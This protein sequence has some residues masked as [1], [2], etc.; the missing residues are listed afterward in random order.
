M[1]KVSTSTFNSLFGVVKPSGPAS[2]TIVNTIKPLLS[3]SPLFFPQGEGGKPAIKGK[4]RGKAALK[5]MVKIGTGG[6]LDPLA[7]GVL[8]LGIGSGTKQLASFLDCVKEYKTTCLLGCETDSYDSQGVRVRVAP[9][10][11]V[12]RENIEAVLDRFRGEIMQT[13]PIFSALK[14]DGRP[15]YEYA[16]E[17]IP[18]PRPIPA[19][20]VTVHSLEVVDWQAGD[21]HSYRWPEETMSEEAREKLKKTVESIVPNDAEKPPLDDQPDPAVPEDTEARPPTFTL[22]MKVSGG[23]YVRSLA[24]DIGHAVGSAAHVVTLTRVR[25]GDF[26]L[27]PTVEN[28]RECVPWEVFE[29]AIKENEEPEEKIVRDENGHRRWEAEVLKRL[30]LQASEDKDN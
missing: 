21:S 23:T 14:M 29:E 26:T 6:T 25:Q 13:P 16:R 18:L 20:P 11:H 15:L 30:V 4:K 22:R 12:T 9:W 3:S 8:V 1:P 24:H 27:E 10:T 28:D 7:D 2:M 5:H 19:R 17:G